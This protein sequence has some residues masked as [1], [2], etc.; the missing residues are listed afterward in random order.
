MWV[1]DLKF[2]SKWK[3]NE[4]LVACKYLFL[5]FFIYTVYYDDIYIYNNSINKV[6]VIIIYTIG[7]Y[8]VPY[9]ILCAYRHHI[10]TY[11]III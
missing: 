6:F 3:K 7:K 1:Y 5:V 11:D 8:T 10:H 4:F 9:S 2:I